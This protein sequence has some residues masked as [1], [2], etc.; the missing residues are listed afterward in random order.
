[1]ETKVTVILSEAKDLRFRSVANSCRFFASLRMTEF[2]DSE[3]RNL[4]LPRG[5]KNQ[6]SGRD[7][8][9]RSE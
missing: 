1:M 5:V 4:A 2:R 8:S 9:L 6:S 7:S 3:A